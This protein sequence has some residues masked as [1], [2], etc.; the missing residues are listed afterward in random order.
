MVSAAIPRRLRKRLAVDLIRRAIDGACTPRPTYCR[1]RRLARW[2]AD[3]VDLGLHPSS[4]L[5]KVGGEPRDTH[6]RLLPLLL[7]S[8]ASHWAVLINTNGWYGYMRSLSLAGTC[9]IFASQTLS[10]IY[11]RFEH[12]PWLCSQPSWQV[13]LFTASKDP[14]YWLDL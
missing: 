4:D 8:P 6:P 9:D 12:T 3:L 14:M 2:C 11:V 10:A 5:P 7:L 1:P 13:P